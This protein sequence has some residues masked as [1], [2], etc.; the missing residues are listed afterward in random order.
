MFTIPLCLSVK[1]SAGSSVDKAGGFGL[2][3]TMRCG[4]ERGAGSGD[5]RVICPPQ[6]STP[7]D[8]FDVSEHAAGVPGREGSDKPRWAVELDSTVTS[9][10]C[11]ADLAG[12]PLD[13]G[14]GFRRDVEIFVE[15][16]VHLADLGVSVLDQQPVP[17]DA[18]A[19]GEV[20]ANDDAS[21]REP[22]AAQ[23]VAHRPQSHERIEVLGSDL[24]PTGAPLA[25]RCTDLEQV[26]SGWRELVVASA[27]LEFGCRNNDSEVLELRETR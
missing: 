13:K 8:L 25:K 10:R 14:F 21:I 4:G 27:P 24:E 17:F 5:G 11:P 2:S 7:A 16:G 9:G 22:V 23:R 18:P 1:M 19:A 20:E 15:A 6:R 12:V 26:M 3:P